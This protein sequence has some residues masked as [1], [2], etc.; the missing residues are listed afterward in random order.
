M[1]FNG[2]T[3]TVETDMSMEEILEFEE[4]VRPRLEYIEEIAVED[5][6][7]MKSSA[8]LAIMES[9]KRTKPELKIPFLEKGVTKSSAYGKLH[10]MTHD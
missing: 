5:T 6:D 3:L 2:D 10:W 9:L 8:F 1:E 4:F 7:A